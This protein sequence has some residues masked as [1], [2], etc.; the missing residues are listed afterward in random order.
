MSD[1]LDRFTLEYRVDTRDSIGRLTRLQD[2]M[3]GVE[4]SGSKA[5]KGIKEFAS[6]AAKELD[7]MI[8]GLSAV[9]NAVKGLGG[10]FAIAAAA[11]GALALGVKSVMALRE[12][13]N[14]QRLA[15][16]QLGVSGLRVENYQRAFANG[17]GGMVSRDAALKGVE[18][19]SQLSNDAFTDPSGMKRFQMQQYLGVNPGTY[20]NPTGLNDEMRQM[21]GFLQG[22]SRDQVKGIAKATGFSQD[23]LMTLQKLGPSIADINQLTQT[24]ITQRQQAEDS[25][26][27]FNAELGT[28]KENVNELEIS[29]GQNLL[30]AAE[31]F[32]GWITKIVDAMNKVTKPNAPTP[33]KIVNGHFVPDQPSAAGSSTSKGHF[34]PGHTWIPDG[35]TPALKQAEVQQ[36]EEKKKE[37]AKASAIVDKMDESNKIGAQTAN[38]TTLAMNLFSSAVASFSQAVDQSQAWA[39]WAGN[40]GQANGIKG[41]SGTAGPSNMST[42][43]GGN[44]NWKNSQYSAQIAAAAAAYGEDP[45]MLY[46]IMM[47]ESHGKNGRTSPTGAKG[48][49]QVTGTNWRAYGNGADIMDPAANIMVG[50]RIYAEQLKKAGGN[51]PKA[52]TGYNGGGDLNYVN[53]VSG[54]YGGSNVGIGQSRDTL[55]LT[56]VQTAIAGAL[57]IPLQQLQ[58]GGIGKG[59]V[60]YTVANLEAGYLNSA[61][62][63]N[64]RLQNPVGLSQ[65]EVSNFKNQVLVAQRGLAAMETYKK[66]IIDGSNGS[67]SLTAQRVGGTMATP[68]TV[69]ANFNI[70]GNVDAQTLAKAINEELEQHMQAAINNVTTNEKG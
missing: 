8:P 6:G 30:P 3:D 7:A 19:L 55:M 13:F 25:L 42:S 64:T 51:V 60:Q 38:Q 1:S 36:A 28:F 27:K 68:I 56:Q 48:L 2:K 50:A 58:R 15:G 12:Q 63:A 67:T 39:S 69:N 10:E 40:I 61:N 22:K 4:R 5:G 29:V 53:T 21:S 33:G 32:V 26:A 62:Q 44:G 35:P 57:G 14:A 11:V 34:G 46:A 43:G 47:T 31:K 23:W 65:I 66:Q 16:M 24:E 54:Y 20:D 49:M 70:T 37:Q 45:Q 18:R 9:A 59:D 17:S 52:L 41:A